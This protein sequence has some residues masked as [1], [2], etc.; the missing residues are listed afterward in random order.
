MSVNP[1]W[2]S[3]GFVFGLLSIAAT[4]VLCRL[5][6]KKPPLPPSKL[7]IR[8]AELWEAAAHIESA[9]QYMAQRKS[10]VDPAVGVLLEKQR[11]ISDAIVALERYGLPE[12]EEK[13]LPNYKDIR[14]LY[15]GTG[16]VTRL[17]DS[18][19]IPQQLEWCSCEAPI[20]C[21]DGGFVCRPC[22]TK[23]ARSAGAQTPVDC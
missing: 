17:S 6:A 20:D 16:H 22:T 19:L 14:L 12:E 1:T 23:S 7:D 2:V 5:L 21:N 11:D 4:V 13:K 15:G 18:S 10:W 8:R 3:I 9:V